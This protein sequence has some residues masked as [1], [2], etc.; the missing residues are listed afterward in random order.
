LKLVGIGASVTAGT[1]GFYSPRERPPHGEGNVESQYAY[2]MM[3]L[4]PHW[5]VLNR[6]M[7]GQR[8][9]QIALRFDYDVLDLH[10][11]AVII[12]AG[13]ND[14]Y[15]GYET[16]WPLRHLKSMIEKARDAGIKVLAGSILPLNLAE[17]PLKEKIREFNRGVRELAAETGTAFFDLYAAMEDT[18]MSGHIAGS[19]DE[20]HP[21]IDGYRRMG[22]LLVEAVESLILPNLPET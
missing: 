17:P 5:E 19:P 10:P 12:I 21:G 1:P 2:W 9:D 8:T 11:D 6:G 22:E 16:V 7:R 18:A 3:R 15:Q 20:V 14:L 13:T 4:R